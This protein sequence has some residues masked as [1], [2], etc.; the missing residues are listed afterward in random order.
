MKMNSS[1]MIERIFDAN[2][3]SLIDKFNVNTQYQRLDSTHIKSNMKQGTRLGLLVAT[4]TKFLKA[5]SRVDNEASTESPWNRG[6]NTPTGTASPP[7]TLSARIPTTPG[8]PCPKRPK[9]FVS[10]SSGSSPRENVARLEEYKLMVRVFGEQC[11][12]KEP[13]SGS[14]LEP[15]VAVKDPKEVVCDGARQPSDPDAGYS[16]HKG[17]GYQAQICETFAPDADPND[18]PLN[19]AAH[20]N[21][22]TASGQDCDAPELVIEVLAAKN[23]PPGT[24]EADTSYGRDA[25]HVFAMKNGVNL[26]SPAAGGNSK[27][28][29]EADTPE[30]FVLG[31]RDFIQPESA[32]R[33]HLADLEPCPEE[34][35]AEAASSRLPNLSDFGSTDLGVILTCPMG[36]APERFEANDADDGGRA[37]FNLEG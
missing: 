36:H 31:I 29:E 1:G 24:P 3:L 30:A 20:V 2:L 13:A 19:L 21:P 7:T 26:I 33:E 27:K 18:K 35:A 9:T 23:I 12:V 14:D 8:S 22:R 17:K 15:T 11:V 37:Y 25:N 32:G 16:G 10:L 4:I 5:L 28:D 6:R 34:T